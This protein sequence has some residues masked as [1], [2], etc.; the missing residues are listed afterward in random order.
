V[1]AVTTALAG[2]GTARRAIWLATERGVARRDGDRW[3]V[4]GD[5]AGLPNVRANALLEATGSDGAPALYAGTSKGVFELHGGRFEPVVGAPTTNVEAMLETKADDLSPILW[6]GGSGG[7]ARREHG[8][9]QTNDERSGLPGRSVAALAQTIGADGSPTLWV[10]TDEGVVRLHAGRWGPFA[11]AGI[12]PTPDVDALLAE[13]PTG[14]TQMLWMGADGGLA[15]VRFGGWESFDVPTRSTSVFAT[16]T[17]R[18]ASGRDVLWIGTRGDGLF[19]FAAGEWTHFGEKDG[20]ASTTVFSLGEVAEKGGGR[21]F[22][23]GTIRG[24]QRLEHDAFSPLIWPNVAIRAMT[25]FEAD[26]GSEALYAATG[27]AGVLHYV[28]GAWNHVDEVTA[29][30]VYDVRPV[31]SPEGDVEVWV[32]T[33]REGILRRKNGA[34]TRFDRAAGGLASD[35]VEALHV[36][37]EKDGRRTLWAGTEGGGVSVLDLDTPGARFVTYTDAT[38]PS[39]PND[40]VYQ[41]REDAG[42]RLYLLT[43][44]GVGRLTLRT[45]TPDDAAPFTVETM[46]TEDGLPSNEFNGGAS[47]VDPEGRVW[48]GTVG[49]VTFFDPKGEVTNVEPSRLYVTARLLAGDRA[50]ARDADL[51]HDQGSVG[52]SYALVTLFRGDDVRYRSQLVGL[53]ASPS[54][55]SPTPRRDFTTLP[56]GRYTFRVWARDYAGRESAPVDLAF[57]VRTAPW[58]TWWAFVLYALIAAGLAYTSLRYRVYALERKN[59]ELAERVA[60]RTRELG[61]KVDELAVSEERARRAEEAAMRAN[62]AK[63]TFLSTMSHELRTPLGAILGFS[64]LIAKDK[65]LAVD[66]Q[67]SVDVIQQSGEHLLVLINDVLSIAKIEAGEVTLDPSVFSLAD[68]VRGVAQILGGRA[69]GKGLRLVSDV[70]PD[71]PPSVR[72]DEGKVRQILLNLVANAIKFTD[73]GG[74]SLRAEWRDGRATFEVTDTGIGI[75]ADDLAKLFAPFAQTV[76]GSRA[77]EGTGL[78]LAISRSFARRMGGD[79]TA[80]S[81]VGE[82]TTFKVEIALEAAAEPSARDRDR[83]PIA[84]L[85]SS[86]PY[87][88]LIADDTRENRSLLR[89]LLERVG[90]FDVHEVTSGEEATEA[91]DVLRPDVVFMDLRMQGI[92]GA[93]ATRRIRAKERGRRAVILAL[94]AS[95]FEHD[96]NGLIAAGCDDFVAKPY[97][98]STLFAKL[99]QHLGARFVYEEVVTPEV[100]AAVP[101]GIVTRDRVRALP[102]AVRADLVAAARVGDVRA[103]RVVVAAVAQ[104][105]ADLG[106]ALKNL[107]DGFRFE[108]IEAQ[109]G[110]D[111]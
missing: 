87:V 72:G 75:A 88:A 103:A 70:G 60:L 45:P 46:T 39:I 58:L 99:E 95:A 55:W 44:K 38:S 105:D 7:L 85:P 23:V 92:D 64:Q 106:R 66:H 49:G 29:R 28:G 5:D 57:R 68:L 25:P 17:T 77:A 53:D 35:S 37:Q 67:E 104:L 22:W 59:V 80:T 34:W 8:V 42:G 54:P 43:N 6:I 109:A 63:S 47:Y 3:I 18:D 1:N 81:V 14:P 36:H 76:A 48:G 51:A 111:G 110:E 101:E 97:R 33:E 50:L 41:V 40:T 96:R 61:A 94:S 100:H 13:P 24:L 4:F 62:R 21:S 15:R 16:I 86:G 65:R 71:I 9:W 79:V 98:E 2:D 89:R 11:T 93:E 90:G 91:Y 102:V 74:V 52:F 32:A 82:G 20:L 84:I 27:D 31:R 26:D 69:R 19:R 30:G 73:E 107:V 108:E 56:A 12:L 78:G 10:A 83:V